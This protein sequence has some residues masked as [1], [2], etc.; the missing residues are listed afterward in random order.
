MS[1]FSNTVKYEIPEGAFANPLN[2]TVEE[3]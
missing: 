2:P 3:V 1:H